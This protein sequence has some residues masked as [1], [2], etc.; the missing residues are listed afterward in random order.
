MK[1]TVDL[2]VDGDLPHIQQDSTAEDVALFH[3]AIGILVAETD[4]TIPQ[5][6]VQEFYQFAMEDHGSYKSGSESIKV[7]RASS[8]K[9][10]AMDYLRVLSR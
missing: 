9:Q 4:G 3:Q 5:N 2:L 1:E 6:R 8:L 7:P 10:F